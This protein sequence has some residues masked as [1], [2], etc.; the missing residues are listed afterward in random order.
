MAQIHVFANSEADG[1]LVRQ[2]GTTGRFGLADNIGGAHVVEEAIVDTA[3]IPCIDA[4]GA[5]ERCVADK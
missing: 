2:D 4:V 5:A 1:V 3:R